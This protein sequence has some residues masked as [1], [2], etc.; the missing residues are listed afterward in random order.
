MHELKE[1][2][3]KKLDEIHQ[4]KVGKKEPDHV[5]LTELLLAVSKDVRSVLNELVAE[6][7]IRSGET[8]NSR[9]IVKKDWTSQ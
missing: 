2:I 5:V 4:S 6:G 8:L 7:R 1:Y 9:Y 3:F